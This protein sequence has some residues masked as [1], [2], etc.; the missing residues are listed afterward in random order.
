MLYPKIILKPGKELPV[1]RFHPWI[2]SGAIS[3]VSENLTDGDIAEVFSSKGKYLATGHFQ[4]S[5]IAVKI[6]TYK[7]QEISNDFWYNR[8]A[9]AY[10]LRRKLNLVSNPVTN[11]YR[12]V[13]NEGDL[14][15]GLIIDIYDETAVIQAHSTGMHRLRETISDAL[16]RLYGIHLKGIYDKSAESLYKNSGIKTENCWLSG[17]GNDVIAVENGCKFSIDIEGGQKTGFFLDQRENRAKTARYAE[18][19]KVLNMFSY[20]GG[21]SVYALKAGAQ[22]VESVD[23]S[24]PACRLAERNVSLN[25][26][27]SSRHRAI[28]ADAR[29]YLENM[30]QAAFDMIILD[31]PAFA[32]NTASRHNAI[33]GY[34]ALNTIALQ[35]IAA[36][37]ILFTFSCSQVV[38]REQFNA[39]VAAAA[40]E[41][42]RRVQILEQLGQA[43]DHPVNI[44]QPESE[45]LKGLILSVE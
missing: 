36:G 31:P 7:Q 26:I 38:T 14:L 30:E 25:G 23:S 37:G 24:A 41:S 6:F 2:F 4:N 27:D 3:S 43:G 44:F 21:F 33:R 18:G 12:L 1:L 32:K 34:S 29:K 42:G 17:G 20:T 40:I 19:K 13:H 28:S 5:S 39:A 9:Q 15:P 45:Y 22:L 16:S 11:C 8:L 35:K 10:A